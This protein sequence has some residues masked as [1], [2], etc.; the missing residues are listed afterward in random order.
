MQ[1]QTFA[2][3]ATLPMKLRLRVDENE[4][5]YITYDSLT[6]ESLMEHV[7]ALKGLEGSKIKAIALEEG[8]RRR[9]DS[10]KRG[11]K[12]HHL[13]TL[14]D[15]KIVDNTAIVIELRTEDEITRQLA[16]EAA[17]EQEE[18]VQGEAQ[19]TSQPKDDIIDVDSTPNIR[20]CVVNTDTDPGVYETI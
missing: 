13:N 4:I 14:A 11:K 19:V 18:A 15:L 17:E 6:I 5:D 3:N 12:D 20:T 9:I 10:K 7:S 16:L 8:K 1:F 2:A